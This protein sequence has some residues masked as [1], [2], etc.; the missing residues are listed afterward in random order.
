[1]NKL[2]LAKML[3]LTQTTRAE[4]DM[5]DIKNL[6]EVDYMSIDIVFCDVINVVVEQEDLMAI[7]IYDL[8]LNFD[9][10]IIL[11]LV[12]NFMWERAADEY[13]KRVH[14]AAMLIGGK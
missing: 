13:L 14:N 12:H 3:G 9:V 11:E 8:D 4:V 6:I 5:H 10:D 1:M 2:E 7:G